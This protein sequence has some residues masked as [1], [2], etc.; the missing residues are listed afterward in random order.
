MFDV[1]ISKKYFY[2]SKVKPNPLKMKTRSFLI[3]ML[4]ISL[5]SCT[6]DKTNNSPNLLYVFPDQMRASTLGFMG[7]EPVMTPNLDLFAKEGIVLTDAASNAPVCSPYRAM[8]MTGCYPLTNGVVSNTTSR[9][10]KLGMQL[11]E[12]DICWSDVLKEKGYSTGYIGKWHLEAPYEPY[13]DCANNRGALKW[14]EWTAPER[15]HGFDFWYTYNTY[16]HHMRPLYWSTNAERDSF[17]YVDQWGPEHEADMAINFIKNVDD[18]YRDKSKPFALVVSMNPPH[19]PYDQ[20]PDRYVRMYD[21]KTDEIQKLINSPSVPDSSDRWG[22]YYRKH[23]TNQLAMV[24][25]VDEQFGRI[26]NALEEEGLKEN[27]IVIFTSDHGDNLG[28]HGKISK[29]NPYEE[30]MNIPFIIRW[31]QQLKPRYDN[32][33]LSVP[34][35]Y[36]T[37]LDLMGFSNQIPSEV[38][39][40]SFASYL[41][42]GKG[43]KPT[44]QLYFIVRNEHILNNPENYPDNLAYDE[45]GVRTNQYTLMINKITEDSV[46]LFLWD[47]IADPFQMDNLAKVKPELFERLIKEELKPWLEKTGDPWTK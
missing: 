41:L 22:K 40:K 45:R 14:N 15:R 19:M 8:F 13:I 1:M 34:D 28:K 24:T 26:L 23:I 35:I 17:H 20:L 46:Q 21:D 9:V 11:R 32:L 6:A 5:F 12:K 25:G 27:T 10:A 37:M 3:L 43:Q 38:E 30:S 18:E 39:G 31:P 42:T 4:T 44:S 29:T 7:E 2:F 16:D 47:R 36:P 33:L